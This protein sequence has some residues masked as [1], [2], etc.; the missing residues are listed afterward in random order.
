MTDESIAQAFDNANKE[1]AFKLRAEVRPLIE[2]MGTHQV[3]V[4]RVESFCGKKLEALVAQKLLEK[5]IMSIELLLHK[6][7]FICGGACSFFVA[8]SFSFKNNQCFD[9]TF[10]SVVGT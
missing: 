5:K 3:I 8:K 4:I 10:R 1:Q 2:S 6:R 7:V 9:C